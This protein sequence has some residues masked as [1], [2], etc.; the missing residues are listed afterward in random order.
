MPKYS[1][2]YYFL[3]KTYKIGS[4]MYTSMVKMISCHF[5]LYENNNVKVSID[6]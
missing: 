1:F 2:N 3:I 5:F 4:R 6:C